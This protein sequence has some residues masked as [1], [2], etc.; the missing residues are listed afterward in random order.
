M[1]HEPVVALVSSSPPPGIRLILISSVAI[2]QITINLLSSRAA[3]DPLVFIITEMDLMD[4]LQLYSLDF[5]HFGSS[6]NFSITS[7][8]YVAFYQMLLSQK[9]I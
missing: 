5:F 3:N 7:S 4:R 1:S 8:Y 9:L 2:S 6:F